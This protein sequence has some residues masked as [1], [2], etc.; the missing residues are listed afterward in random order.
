M[1][2]FVVVKI[3]SEYITLGQFLKFADIISNGGEAKSYI[4]THDI[5]VNGEF[6]KM[7]GKKL[8]PKSKV[9]IDN[10]LFFE[11]GE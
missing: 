3:E 4:A 7:R 5:F 9:V 10:S 1:D 11:I 6:C 2:K 8:Y